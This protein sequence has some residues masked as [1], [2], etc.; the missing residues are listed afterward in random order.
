[1]GWGLGGGGVFSF[2]RTA[3]FRLVFAVADSVVVDVV[4][5]VVVVVV[6]DRGVSN[7]CPLAP[8]LK[9]MSVCVCYL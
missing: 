4:I 1:M 7:L 5:V 8:T 6:V 3:L 9:A 2:R